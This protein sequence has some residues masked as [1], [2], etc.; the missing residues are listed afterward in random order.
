MQSG[1]HLRGLSVTR[2]YI[3]FYDEERSF[4]ACILPD[5][6][7]GGAYNKFDSILLRL[8]SLNGVKLFVWA[9]RVGE[10]ELAITLDPLPKQSIPW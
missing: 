6:P 1:G 7:D 10:W 2:E 4:Y 9:R 8:G 5:T 3:S